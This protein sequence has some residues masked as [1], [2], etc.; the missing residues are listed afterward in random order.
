MSA[1]ELELAA[2]V[3]RVAVRCSAWL[4]VAVI[5][6]NVWIMGLS[7]ITALLLAISISLVCSAWNAEP[8]P[9][10]RNWAL[11]VAVWTLISVGWMWRSEVL[12]I[13]RDYW[14]A[15]YQ[16]D[17]SILQIE[18]LQLHR[19]NQESSGHD[20]GDGQARIGTRQAASSESNRPEK[21]ASE[22]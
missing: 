21:V 16:K 20:Y 13:Q 2:T 4:A 7:L 8:R 14:I 17:T 1:F 6:E 10:I 11:L 5:S 9:W 19:T 18:Q 3:T 22:Q 15:A 12:Q